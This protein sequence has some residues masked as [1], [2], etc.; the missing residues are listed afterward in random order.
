LSSSTRCAIA[1][2][3]VAMA[4]TVSSV[5]AQP[6]TGMGSL[7]ARLGVPYFLA[8][9]DTKTGE[10]PRILGTFHFQYKAS[11]RWRFSTEFGYG[12]VGYDRAP[13]PYPLFDPSTGDSV[14]TK[15]DV[16]TKI[17]PITFTGIYALRPM[18][19]KWAP[20]V[21]AGINITRMEI[22]NKREK[23]QDPATFEKWV[24]WS[25]SV[26]GEI[27]TE[28]FVQSKKTVALDWSL[29]GA[30]QFSKD[31]KR[32]PSGFTGNDAYVALSFGVNVYFWPGGKKP[33]DLAPPAA[34][35]SD[36]PAPAVPSTPEPPPPATPDTTKAPA[37]PAPVPATP[38]T[39]KAPVPPPPPPAPVPAVPD[40]T[41]KAPVMSAPVQAHDVAPAPA[42]VAP[43]GD[44]F[45]AFGVPLPAV[46]PD[47]AS[48]PAR[49]APTRREEVVEPR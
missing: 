49:P 34:P 41:K 3:I 29:K 9:S 36:N 24:K 7:G 48:C 15:V 21:G 37:P 8:D 44:T 28:L 31:T 46:E 4:A 38:D 16:L 22:V 42:E 10:R 32:F 45:G 33:V 17:Q 39:T 11:P 20:Y 26:Q 18:S 43:A 30:Y 27:G 1:V 12:W 19:T 5:H 2:W 35:S 25:P 6:R 14:T 40:T 13:S 23:I 47:A